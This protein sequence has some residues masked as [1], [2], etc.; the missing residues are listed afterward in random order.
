VGQISE[1][2]ALRQHLRLVEPF[3]PPFIWNTAFVL[4]LY[5]Q[6]DEALALLDTLPAGAGATARARIYASIGRFGDAADVLLEASPDR[7]PRGLLETAARLLRAAP[8]ATSTPESLPSLGVFAWVYT[9]IGASV[10]FLE[11]VEPGFEAGYIRLLGDWHSS[12]APMRRTG[13]F[14]ARIS[15]GPASSIIGMSKVGRISAALEAPP[16][17]SA[18]ERFDSPRTL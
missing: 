1:A 13:E 15:A 4:W 8:A 11:Y 5:G 9:Y 3:V 18:I 14:K 7:Y 17:S 10:R 6:N 12:S 16:I 2:V